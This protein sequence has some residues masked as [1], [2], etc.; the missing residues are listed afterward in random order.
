M[1]E[2]V[3]EPAPVQ[4]PAV[5][6]VAAPA[7]AVGFGPAQVLALQ[8][9]A[10]NAA[11]AAYLRRQPAPAATPPPAAAGPLTAGDLEGSI[12]L[13]SARNSASLKARVDK[14]GGQETVIVESDVV[15][16][17]GE[18]TAKENDPAN[19]GATID[20]DVRVGF[21]QTVEEVGRIGKYTEDGTPA[22]KPYADVRPF[23]KPGTRDVQ[24]QR[25]AKGA[26]SSDKATPPFYDAFQT[27]NK[28]GQTRPLE[29]MDRLSHALDLEI[30]DGK[31][32]LASLSGT[33]RFRTSVTAHQPPAA[34]IHLDAAEWSQDWTMALDPSTHTGTGAAPTAQTFKG[35][36]AAIGTPTG[37]ANR[38]QITWTAIKD[39][40]A[41]AQL[42]HA[43]LLQALPMAREQDRPVY[44]AMA[45]RLR[46]ENPKLRFKL[47]CIDDGAYTEDVEFTFRVSGVRGPATRPGKLGSGPT[48]TSTTEFTFGILD[49]FD[50]NDVTFGM[51]LTVEVESK[52]ATA[53]K[54]TVGKLGASSGATELK[55]G[56]ATY[57]VTS[58]GF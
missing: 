37:A 7:P 28:R 44:E 32:K 2:H 39:P 12:E 49:F 53:A 9:S 38:D 19:P 43:E 24:G 21:V 45:K 56:S 29:S 47:D 41:L 57:K 46:D 58:L 51:Q 14:I 10:G 25:T 15:D 42:S 4:A 6:A 1:P 11:T 52:G 20:P 17:K 48:A 23:V 3:H 31:G 35:Q 18:V 40:A 54:T 26:A 55:S 16:L 33:D 50:P 34:P 36:L 30:A 27:L 13:P 22:G 8:R 5:Q